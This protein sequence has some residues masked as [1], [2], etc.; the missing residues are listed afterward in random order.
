MIEALSFHIAAAKPS[1]AITQDI[2]VRGRH[3]ERPH[4]W[5]NERCARCAMHRE[6][7]GARHPCEG[8]ALVGEAKA[9]ALARYQRQHQALR[10]D[11]VKWQRKL[12]QIAQSKAKKRAV[13]G[14]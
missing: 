3:P 13:I 4:V 10:A 14:Q 1:R 5:R 6:W 12:E 11:P 8:V 2:H 7:P 9:K